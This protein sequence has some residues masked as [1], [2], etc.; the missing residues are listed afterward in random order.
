MKK[1]LLCAALASCFATS[2]AYAEEAKP[3]EPKPDNE[4]AFNVGVATE[5]RF[6]GVSQTRNDPSV[7]GGADY[8]NNPTGLYAGIWAS[9]IKW[10]KDAGGGGNAEIDIYGGIKG[11]VIKDVSYD[12]GVLTYVYP[13]NHLGRVSGFTNAATTELYGQL[14]YGPFY[15]KYSHAVT[16]TFG[17]VDSKNSGYVDL[18]ANVEL[19]DGFTLNLHVGR[20]FFKNNGAYSY[21]DWKVGLTKEFFGLTFNLAALG[22]DAERG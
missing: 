9:S 4:V 20:Q 22:T 2:A 7:Q 1:L 12:V 8:V 19:T 14:G 3:A 6:R 17:F 21:T 11:E 5:Y 13:S 15:A 10:I 16:D 18:G